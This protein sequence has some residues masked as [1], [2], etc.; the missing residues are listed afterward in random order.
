MSKIFHGLFASI[1]KIRNVLK[2]TMCEKITIN[3]AVSDAAEK[4]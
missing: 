2:I 1:E 3:T 4:M